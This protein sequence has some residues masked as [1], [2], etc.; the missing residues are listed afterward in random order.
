MTAD[1]EPRDDL[2][3][4][5]R[6][7]HDGGLSYPRLAER[8]IDPDTGHTLGFQW[9][10]RL[11]EGQLAKAPDAWQLR[12]LA[13]GLNVDPDMIKGLAAR[14]WLEFEV[15][16][17][18]LGAPYEWALYLEQRGLSP[19]ETEALRLEVTRFIRRQESKLHDKGEGSDEA[20]A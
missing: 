11:A 2:S 7:K 9:L 10:A 6:E 13:V 4:F 14:Q 3:R 16:Q 8:A 1:H 18:S 20:H 17:V 5:L 12:A 19:E 15:A